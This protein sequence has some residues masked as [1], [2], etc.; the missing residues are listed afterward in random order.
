MTRGNASPLNSANYRRTLGAS[1][2]PPCIDAA[3]WSDSSISICCIAIKCDFVRPKTSILNIWLIYIPSELIPKLPPN[4]SLNL[5]RYAGHWI[6]TRG[7]QIF[8]QSSKIQSA[9]RGHLSQESSKTKKYWLFCTFRGALSDDWVNVHPGLVEW[10]R[11]GGLARGLQEHGVKCVVIGDV[12]EEWYL[13]SIAHPIKSPEDIL[14]NMERY[15]PKQVAQRMIAAFPELPP[16]AGEQESARFY[17]EIMSL[18]QVYLPARLFAQEMMSHGFPVL[19]Y[20]IGW[21]PEQ[22]R[23]YGKHPSISLMTISH[24]NNI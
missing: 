3:N 22:H 13:Y 12:T 2:T 11:S 10:Q 7:L 21:S 19:R 8:L 6:S 1:I 18:G 5:M 23:P 14:P 4:S 16:D 20:E 15:Y 24:N 17:G 9:F